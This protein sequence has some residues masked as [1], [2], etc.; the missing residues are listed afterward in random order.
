MYL[1]TGITI[2][3]IVSIS[4]VIVIIWRKRTVG[5]TAC[6]TESDSTS[7]NEGLLEKG[8][9]WRQGFVSTQEPLSSDRRSESCP[10]PEKSEAGEVGRGN[11][12][13]GG[14]NAA[15]VVVIR[16]TGGTGSQNG[17]I[18]G[19]GIGIPLV[20]KENQSSFLCLR[21]GWQ[22]RYSPFF[23]IILSIT[24]TYFD[25]RT[26]HI[27][28]AIDNAHSID[29]DGGGGAGGMPQFGFM[30]VLSMLLPMCANLVILGQFLYERYAISRPSFLFHS[31]Y[32]SQE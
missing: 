20:E 3:A 32:F 16:R 4:I 12:E 31:F 13:G 28:K 10:L 29:I 9:V 8:G 1:E 7:M 6:K 17:D 5:S 24:D 2:A 25:V 19:G 21:D 14:R 30:Y 18:G 15:K 27:L 11:A 23:V 22:Q 26:V